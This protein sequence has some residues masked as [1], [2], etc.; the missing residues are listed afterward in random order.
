MNRLITLL[1]SMTLGMMVVTSWARTNHET[2][3]ETLVTAT[4]STNP[5]LPTSQ[6]AVIKP[7]LQPRQ[8]G[9][10]LELGTLAVTIH[11]IQ[12]LAQLSTVN[13][14]IAVDLTIE[15]TTGSVID[16]FFFRIHVRDSDGIYYIGDFMP[17]EF[18]LGTTLQG[19]KRIRGQVLLP[20]PTTAT[21]LSL[22]IF[23]LQ[24][25]GISGPYFTIAIP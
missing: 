23:G 25:N 4:F 11:G 24:P 2:D 5:T 19:Q 22:E 14:A 18:E 6:V 20:V 16:L 3:S 17:P 13:K 15:N 7:T 12:Q 10:T 1:L 8:V 9:E 21:G